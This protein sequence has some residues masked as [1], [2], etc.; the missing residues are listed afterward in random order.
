MTPSDPSAQNSVPAFEMR[1]HR[2]KPLTWETMSTAQQAMT[3]AVM[4]GKRGAMQG[5]Y[6][7][8]LRSPV[9][10]N[11]AQQFGAQTRFDSS[12]PLALNELAIL[13]MARNWTAQFVWWAHRTIAEEAGLPLN[14]VQCIAQGCEAPDDL[15]P[16]VRAVFKFCREL[17]DRR[18]VSD[19]SYADAV[20]HFGERGVVDLMATLSYYTLVCMSL[21]VDQYPLPEGAEPEL[22]PLG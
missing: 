9:V 18:Q 17:I 13:M 7:V 19:E 14:L 6:N 1:G 10:G 3:R 15:A 4:S 5:P 12:L 8:L 21:N 2:F 11:L 20:T 22:H 16:E